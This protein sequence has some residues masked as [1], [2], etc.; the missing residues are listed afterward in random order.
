MDEKVQELQI[1]LA[2][3]TATVKAWM[4]TTQAYR[5]SLCDKINTIQDKLSEL[6]CRERRGWYQGM[7]KQVT[8]MWAVLAIFI[9]LMFKGVW[10]RDQISK[11]LAQIK[12]ELTL[13]D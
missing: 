5:L 7:N 4:E 12:N 9:V 1:E 2:S 11:E 10:D 8:F 13:D 3:F 6:P